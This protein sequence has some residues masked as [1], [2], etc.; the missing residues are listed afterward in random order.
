VA[1]G[2]ESGDVAELT[3]AVLT[4]SDRVS[5]GEAEDRSGPLAAQMLE[6]LG[7][8]VVTV[9]VV[10]DGVDFVKGAL[11]DLAAQAALIVTTGGTGL[12]PRDVTPEATAEVIDREVPGLV[13]AM[14]SATF[15]VNPHG[16][17]SRA[18]AGIHES[19]LILNLPGST[20][21]VAESLEVVGP[22]LRH[23]VELLLSAAS[24]HNG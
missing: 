21:G 11:F 16:M 3:A 13:E 15:G 8:V 2:Q 6:A 5:R 4:V 17:L 1:E 19:T 10:P 22:A 18:V 12:A 14:R 9:R 24:D 7:F 23:G 20:R